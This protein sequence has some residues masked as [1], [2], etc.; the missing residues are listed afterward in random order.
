M[1]RKHRELA[2]NF[3]TQLVA[4]WKG[5]FTTEEQ[6]RW[7]IQPYVLGPRF[8]D[9]VIATQS[10]PPKGILRA[11]VAAVTN[12]RDLLLSLRAKQTTSTPKYTRGCQLQRADGAYSWRVY[13]SGRASGPRLHFWRKPSGEVELH[14]VGTHDELLTK[15]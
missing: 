12:R 11:A 7:P 4:T 3:H 5:L 6:R 13:V 10:A 15:H 9:S 14:A 8:L 1:S 2:E